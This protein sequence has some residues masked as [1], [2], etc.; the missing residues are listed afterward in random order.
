VSRHLGR[1]CLAVGTGLLLAAAGFAVAFTAS[2]KSLASV[3]P[4][5]QTPGKVT[6]CHR[7]GS[8]SNP[9]VT[10]TVSPDSVSQHESQ[11]DTIGPCGSTTSSSSTSTSS[12]S[13]GSTRSTTT[14]SSSTTTT[15]C[16][17]TTTSSTS[18]TTSTTHEGPSADLSV[19]ISNSPKSIV[20]QRGVTTYAVQ[21]HNGGPDQARA[22]LVVTFPTELFPD[23]PGTDACART[24]A[25][26]TCDFSLEPGGSAAVTIRAHAQTT[27][28]TFAVTAEVES[29]LF[30]PDPSNNTRSSST[31]VTC[32]LCMT[33]TAS[34][35]VAFVGQTLTYTI[36]VRN[37][38][39]SLV[40]DVEIVDTLPATVTFVEKGSSDECSSAPGHLVRCTVGDLSP[41]ASATRTIVVHLDGPP[42]TIVNT[43]TATG[44]LEGEEIPVD[45]VADVAT[46]TT[47]VPSTADLEL[48][49]TAPASVRPGDPITYTLVV[50]NHGPSTTFNTLLEDRLPAATTFVSVSTSRG[51]CT[52]GAIVAC[53]LGSLGAERANRATI[54]IV[55][56]S[57]CSPPIVNTAHVFDAGSTFE[58]PPLATGD[59]HPGDNTASATTI[60]DCADVAV[61]KSVTPE[62]A[63]VGD[64]ITYVVGVTNNGPAPAHGILV[65][66][67]LP[68]EVSFESVT[69]TA[70]TC[71]GGVAVACTIETLAVGSSATITIMTRAVAAGTATNVAVAPAVDDPAH[72]GSADPDLTNNSASATTR[73][74]AANLSITKTAAPT[75]VGLHDRLTY[76]ITVRNR[77]PSAAEHVRLGDDVPAGLG[78]VSV[79]APVG[80]C[81]SGAHVVCDLGAVADGA[82]VTVHVVVEAQ[83]VGTQVNT[84]TVTSTTHDGDR[85]DNSASATTHVTSANLSISKTEAPNPATVGK[86]VVYTLTVANAGPSAA[87]NVRVVDPLPRNVTFV[88]A[89]PSQG[90]C[91]GRSTV[92]CALGTIAAGAKATVVIRVVP[93]AAG[94]VKNV[95]TVASSTQDPTRS[96][97]DDG[98]TTAV[99]SADLSVRLRA[100]PDPVTVGER[101]D[102]VAQVDDGGP[103]AASDVV[104]TLDLPEGATLVDRGR[105]TGDR[106]LTCNLGRLG[107][108]ASSTLVVTVRPLHA[109]LMTAR[110]HVA[111]REFDRDAGNDDATAV[112]TA[113]F[114]PS[115]AAVP[116]IGSPGFVTTAVGS[117]FPATTTV[118]LGWQPGLGSLLVR[119]D[120]L[121]RFRLPMLVL[122]K[123][124]VGPRRLVAVSRSADPG[125]RFAPVAAAFLVVPGTLEPSGFVERR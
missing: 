101:L 84:A 119:T 64:A 16:C 21:V 94:T 74:T 89:K 115:L 2:S 104:L 5:G 32:G 56:T 121:G 69:T 15:S 29:R 46:A 68:A 105:C 88:S 67:V 80:S 51:A 27:L 53:D 49:K 79:S 98:T 52:G 55:A 1:A 47:Q 4:S 99:T 81:T 7:T 124:T 72:G 82:S 26:V 42:G 37:A 75:T 34:K 78:F 41:G 62:T 113:R 45:A 90:T 19:E 122:S 100:A 95:A 73:I 97:N 8:A 117:G 109:G 65:Q 36:A 96:N 116:P 50:T 118:L 14:S 61:T 6:M 12:T 108:A 123:D 17:T 44:L 92:R 54:V 33:K 114:L 120:G 18:S 87:A 23:A 71:T 102:Y 76:T 106:R 107:L 103:T 57:S 60:P 25:T 125:Q 91:T 112:A 13:T 9:F 77:G 28:G 48:T 66:D 85:S 40:T 24:G 10:I 59:P 111:G 43:A 11:G 86:P 22:V 110:A 3:R 93:R 83:A 63:T 58:G 30:D 35:Q 39:D 70:G 20:V 38:Y 31:T